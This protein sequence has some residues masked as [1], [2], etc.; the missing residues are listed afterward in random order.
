MDNMTTKSKSKIKYILFIRLRH[1]KPKASVGTK[2]PRE[3]IRYHIYQ[4][5]GHHSQSK[6]LS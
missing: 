4:D 1:D 2:S 5:K 6:V 3:G